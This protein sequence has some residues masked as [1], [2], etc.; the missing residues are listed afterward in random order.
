VPESGIPPVPEIVRLLPFIHFNQ[1][2]SIKKDRNFLFLTPIPL[3]TTVV[4]EHPDTSRS[5]RLTK[6]R[7]PVARANRKPNSF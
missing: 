7:K 4:L 1:N 6:E 5:A 2:I 3:G